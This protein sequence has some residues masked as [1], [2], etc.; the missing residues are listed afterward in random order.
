M[1]QT[2]CGYCPDCRQAAL[3]QRNEKLCLWCGAPLSR[4]P[5]SDEKGPLPDWLAIQLHG[6]YMTD[7]AKVAELVEQGI[8]SLELE[9][10]L[11]SA[12]HFAGAEQMQTALRERWAKLQLPNRVGRPA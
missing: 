12:L 6:Q 2:L 4:L 1:I 9:P 10:P 8:L 5:S 3:R 11:W 7:K